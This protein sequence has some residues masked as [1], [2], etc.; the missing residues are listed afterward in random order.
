MEAGNFNSTDKTWKTS[1]QYYPYRPIA[2]TICLCKIYEKIITHHLDIKNILTPYQSGF[3]KGHSTYDGMVKLESGKLGAAVW[4]VT[5]RVN[6]DCRKILQFSLQ[7]F[8]HCIWQFNIFQCWHIRKIHNM[9]RLTEFIASHWEQQYW[10]PDS[11][12]NCWY[13]EFFEW[14]YTTDVGA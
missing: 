5:G 2:L 12:K 6:A 1:K 7:S 8:G 14:S 11:E 3:R 9:H 13:N 10:A 4:S